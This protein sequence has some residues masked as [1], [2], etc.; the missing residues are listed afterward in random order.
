MTLR[1]LLCILAGLGS[2]TVI[3][4]SLPSRVRRLWVLDVRR[5]GVLARELVAHGR[6]SGDDVARRFSNRSAACSGRSRRWADWA[7]V[8]GVPRSIARWHAG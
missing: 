7:V 8:R 4:Y 1:R 3:D 5:G 6:N 2:L